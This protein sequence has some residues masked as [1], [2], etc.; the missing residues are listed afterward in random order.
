VTKYKVRTNFNPLNAY[1]V[2][3]PLRQGL[4]G[5]AKQRKVDLGR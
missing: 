5:V 3:K 4:C 1:S 2:E